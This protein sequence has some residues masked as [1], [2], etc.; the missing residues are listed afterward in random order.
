M[1]AF[2][3]IS[4]MAEL[5]EELKDIKDELRELRLLYKQLAEK[6]I[7]VVKPAKKEKEAIE[8]KDEIV[9]EEV[10]MKSLE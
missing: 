8:Q 7:L 5:S 4:L 10:L 6:V 3:I 9:S 2:S 1:L